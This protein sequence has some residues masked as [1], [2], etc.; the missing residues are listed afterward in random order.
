M[1]SETPRRERRL[2]V[3]GAHSAARLAPRLH[4]LTKLEDF[5]LLP[6]SKGAAQLPPR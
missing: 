5:R 2:T 6:L 3:A 1:Q 4:P